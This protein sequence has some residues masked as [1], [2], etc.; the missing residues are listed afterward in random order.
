MADQCV[1]AVFSDLAT[2]EA[3][4]AELIE[5]GHP[6]G[7]VTLAVH[8]LPHDTTA[9]QTLDLPDGSLAEAADVG[10][11]GAALGA[12]VGLAASLA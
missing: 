10:Q 12:A 3:A 2:A 4:Q 1:V 8:R 7:Q 9:W 5:A 6:P 11:S